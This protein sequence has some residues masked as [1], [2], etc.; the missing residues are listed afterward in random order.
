[1]EDIHLSTSEHPRRDLGAWDSAV[2]YPGNPRFRPN[3]A[4][5][6]AHTLQEMEGQHYKLVH[7]AVM[8]NDEGPLEV[9]S[10]E[11]LKDI[12]SYQ[13]GICKQE[14]Y[15]YHS[16]PNSFIAIFSERHA[17]DVIF[18]AGRAIEGSI[19]LQFSSSDPDDFSVRTNTPYHIRVYI[20]GSMHHA[21][22]QHIADKVLCD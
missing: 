10:C 9:R 12:I 4:F 11:D 2:N 1:M 14:F 5:K 6:M 7:H 17:R 16:L 21:W 18:S 8:I 3:V 15:V 20:E 22:S 19:E 13:F